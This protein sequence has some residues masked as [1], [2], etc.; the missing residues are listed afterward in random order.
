LR[1]SVQTGSL[2]KLREM[3]RSRCDSL[4]FGDEFCQERLPDL[5]SLREAL[6]IA[7]GKRFVYV[8]PRVSTRGLNLIKG[9]LDA[10]QEQGGL[11]V[12]ANDLGVLNLLRKHRGLEPHLGRQLVYAPARCPWPDIGGR[13]IASSPFHA[14]GVKYARSR[15]RDLFY[16][17]NLSY[18]PTL[19][20]LKEYG[21]QTVE[22]DWIPGSFDYYKFLA[23][24]GLRLSVHSH[25]VPVTV[26][27]RCHT[28]RLSGEKS[29]EN[30]SKPCEEKALLLRHRKLGIDLHLQGNTVFR[31]EEPTR[32]GMR[33]LEENGVEEVV[34]AIGP[35]TKIENRR[36][37]ERFLKA[38]S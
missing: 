38:M 13:D 33:E 35:L 7:K 26:T 34:V 23:E 29:P 20:L 19:E 4:R 12:V 31:L 9:C 5:A 24:Y 10:L 37:L 18:L 14:F 30:C 11:G 25:L 2:E 17:T 28:A 6:R 22:L 36:D 32:Q 3:A 21:V 27:R 1:F 16:Q 8:T 15:V